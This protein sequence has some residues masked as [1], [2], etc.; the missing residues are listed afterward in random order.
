MNIQE[1]QVVL[2]KFTFTEYSEE[3]LLFISKLV[4]DESND[5]TIYCVSRALMAMNQ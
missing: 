1:F 3:D 5:E 4:S 2:D